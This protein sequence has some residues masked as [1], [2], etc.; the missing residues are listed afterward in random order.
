MLDL[1]PFGPVSGYTEF[2]SDEF[3]S[4]SRP[5][6]ILHSIS[7]E[8]MKTGSLDELYRGI[9]EKGLTE[10][11]F[12]RIGLLLFDPRTSMIQ[13]TWG[14]DVNG[15]L[16]DESSFSRPLEPE[17]TFIWD[18][19]ARKDHVVVVK[20]KNLWHYDKIVGTGWNAVVALRDQ[21]EPFGWIAVDNLVRQQPCTDEVRNAIA[22]YG[23]TASHLIVRKRYE[24]QLQEMVETK[25]AALERTMEKLH[26][27]E[28]LASLG[29]LVAGVA[30]EINTPLGN[31]VLGL[32]FSEEV[33]RELQKL[34]SA[35]TI[36]RQKLQKGMTEAVEALASVSVNL[37]RTA[38]LVQRFKQ[39]ARDQHEEYRDDSLYLVQVLSNVQSSFQH[40]L[41]MAKISL[42]LDVPRDL[43]VSSYPG[44]ISQIVGNFLY[45]TI[46]HGYPSVQGTEESGAS[47][48]IEI[49]ASIVSPEQWL[50]DYCDHGRGVPAALRARI[51]EPFFTTARESGG[52]GL[53]L[54]IVHTLVHQRMGGTLE[55]YEPEGGGLGYRLLFPRGNTAN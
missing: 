28:R 13:G 25:T 6:R 15:Q 42:V 4:E 36:T 43:V 32:S 20:E 23:S 31:A 37:E 3:F 19:L 53:G 49:R 7:L 16:C 26:A 41:R 30:H 44:M 24:L 51:F 39:L 12:D 27:S 45:N 48:R 17:S 38:Q 46:T 54:S 2:M 8:L 14:T 22:F 1:I 21:D 9:V 18:A 52:S 55:L 47:R 29:R 40:N 10:L 11:G 34:V 35:E 5:L 33:V 50:L